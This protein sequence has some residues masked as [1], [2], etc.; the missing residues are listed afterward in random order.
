MKLT[1]LQQLLNEKVWR[2]AHSYGWVDNDGNMHFGEENS[3]HG[4]MDIDVGPN[5][6]Q[7][8]RI[9]IQSGW[10]A[11][12][13]EGGTLYLRTEE[14][15]DLS[16]AQKRAVERFARSKQLRIVV[17]EELSLD[18]VPEQPYDTQRR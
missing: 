9:L 2:Q 17:D 18:L 14:Y 8:Y 6:P 13:I 5:S 10:I 3:H 11:W 1:E 4:E 7:R 16:S 12:I 15:D